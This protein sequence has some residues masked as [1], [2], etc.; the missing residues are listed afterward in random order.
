MI[1]MTAQNAYKGITEAAESICCA[2]A[3]Q[4][5]E[6]ASIG[7]TARQGDL[8]ITLLEAVPAGFDKAAVEPQLAPGTTK[9]SRHILSHKQVRMYR[10]SNADALTGPVIECRKS[11]T[12][13]HPEHGD[14]VLPPGVYGI[15][16][17]RM[18]AEELRRQVD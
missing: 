5:P 7:D 15:T 6:A 12:V 11:V 8:Y 13:T 10:D 18:F 17:Q 9:G 4:F 14:V 1:E 3:Q 2:D 16:Y